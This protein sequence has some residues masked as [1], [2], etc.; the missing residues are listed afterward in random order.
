MSNHTVIWIHMSLSYTLHIGQWW[1]HGPSTA[2]QIQGLIFL[3]T[4]KQIKHHLSQRNFSSFSR[5]TWLSLQ[6]GDANQQHFL[7][8]GAACA[9]PRHA[10]V[11]GTHG[12][13]G[14]V[15]GPASNGQTHPLKPWSITGSTTPLKTSWQ[16]SSKRLPAQH[17][18]FVFLSQQKRSI[19]TNLWPGYR[20]Y[21]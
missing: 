20:R 11:P 16:Y 4:I 13:E 12:A 14:D 19:R 8:S 18:S 6:T 1:P 15:Q 2:F 5:N 9:S 17:A 3:Y 10:L 21:Y 7:A